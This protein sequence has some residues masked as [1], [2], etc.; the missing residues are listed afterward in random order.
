MTVFTNEFLWMNDVAKLILML[1]LSVVTCWLFDLDSYTILTPLMSFLLFLEFLCMVNL[2]ARML[3][4]LS[5][6][7]KEVA[8]MYPK[9]VHDYWL[10]IL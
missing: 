5:G 4:L 1:L 8:R 10:V 9:I 7:L 2:Q 3:S 6:L